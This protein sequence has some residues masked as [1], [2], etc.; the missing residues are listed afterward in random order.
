MPTQ[1]ELEQKT[2]KLFCDLLPIKD[3]S[4]VTPDETPDFLISIDDL[5]IGIELTELYHPSPQKGIYI[6]QQEAIKSRIIRNTQR[7]VD[8]EK[9]P[10][11]DAYIS[12]NDQHWLPID[13]SS[14]KL[15]H[16]HIKKLPI[17]IAKFIREN[18]PHEGERTELYGANIEEL[19]IQIDLILITREKY[20]SKPYVNFAKGG[21]IPFLNFEY[22]QS[23]ITTKNNKL[24]NYLEKCNRC[25]LLISTNDFI[26]EKAFDLEASTEA[27]K[28]SYNYQFER[29][30][31]IDVGKESLIELTNS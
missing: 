11:I 22:L 1:K 23:I 27:L 5:I 14:F 7:I 29:V 20:F 2:F 4:K 24:P 19:P 25:W 9:L 3:L 30:F 8:R 18:I 31:I 12:F 16:A 28:A 21:V 17:V 10:P 15:T 6:Q 26:Y 13:T